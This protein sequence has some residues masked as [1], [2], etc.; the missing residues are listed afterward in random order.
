[1]IWIRIHRIDTAFLLDAYDINMISM[2]MAQEPRAFRQPQYQKVILVDV[3]LLTFLPPKAVIRYIAEELANGIWC[4][5]VVN[6][7]YCAVNRICE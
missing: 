6:V 5:I 7:T 4:T 3:I 1:M 2:A